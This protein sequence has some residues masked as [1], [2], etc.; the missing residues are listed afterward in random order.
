MRKTL[1]LAKREYKAAVH[2]KGFIVGLVLAP[3]LMGGGFIALALMK[4]HMDTTDKR[5]AVV[6][7]SGII[8]QAIVEA[9]DAR[10][11]AEVY[12]ETG[13]KVKPAYVIEVIEAD[14]ENPARQRLRLSDGVRRAG[15]HAFVEIGPGVLHPQEGSDGARIAYYSKNAAMD[16]VRG[17]LQ[18]P[19]N[20]RLRRMRLAEAGVEESQVSDLFTWIS[21][22]GL[23]LVS[24]DAETGQVKD[25]ER[26]SE[27]AAFGI[28]VAMLMLMFLM[29]FMG[30]V[31]LL[32]A[33]MEEK[34][35]RIAEVVLGSVTPFQFMVGKIMGGLGVSLTAASVYVVGGVLA[36]QR[37]DLARFIPYDILPW[38][39][40]FMLL[41]IVMLG[42]V[43][44]ALGS[45]CNDAK[46]A[47]SMTMP[48][49]LPV[50]IP[51]FLLT[52]LI[53]EPQSSFATVMS[54]IPPFTPMVMLLR[55]STPVGVPAWQPWVAAC[56][57]VCFAVLAIWAGGRIFRVGILMQGKPPRIQDL[58]RWAIRG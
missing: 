4:D 2:T 34:T 10:N 52:P 38:F 30:A 27:A 21:V 3:I 22:E 20:N 17:W 47:Q 32:N 39:F 11:T 5:I 57:V 50:M 35:Q 6:D 41:N 9:A 31:P 23:G 43:F 29:T 26:S 55:Q 28:P 44:A 8:A 13:K 51:L 58:L 49:M 53:R 14:R 40:A 15:L 37:M 7:R 16:D 18:W 54:F 19:I 25:A 1:L 45:A 36:L 12:D 56:G 46:E 24:L 42:A 48:A 33:V